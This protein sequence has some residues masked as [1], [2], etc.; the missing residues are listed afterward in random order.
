[1]TTTKRRPEA[2]DT[3]GKFA[4]AS[5]G[6]VSLALAVHG[7]VHPLPCIGQKYDCPEPEQRPADM[8]EPGWP[9]GPTSN[10]SHTLT[11]GPT[12]PAAGPGNYVVNAR[13]D[14]FTLTGG[15]AELS[16][17]AS[18]RASL[19]ADLTTGPTGPA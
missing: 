1:M 12:G 9:T 17:S 13:P 19:T 10:G 6:A 8:P 11:T 2:M 7:A 4:A 3:K 16:A 18:A 15:G 14:I 5:V